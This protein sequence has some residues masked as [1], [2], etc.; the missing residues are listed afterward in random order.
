MAFFDDL[1][2]KVTQA[3]QST[4]QK[5]KELSEITKLNANIAGFERQINDLYSKLGYEVYCAYNEAPLPEVEGLILQLKELHENIEN[6]R[7]QIKA[8]S[9]VD[10]CPN[11]GARTSKE[12]LFCSA[13]G[14]RLPVPQEPEEVVEVVQDTLFCGNCGAELSS[15]AI[16]CTSCGT[17]VG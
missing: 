15:D 17:K 13:C 1:K 10:T 14:F 11:C 5:A 7:A 16:F 3:S 9:A 6:C 4:V 12:M 2:N 8:I